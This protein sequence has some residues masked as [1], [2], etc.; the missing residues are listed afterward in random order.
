MF[1]PMYITDELNENH[2]IS[3]SYMSLF[4][5]IEEAGRGNNST[6]LQ[7]LL[8]KWMFISFGAYFYPFVLNTVFF[9]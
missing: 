9:S 3:F 4:F 6:N 2:D 5:L 7:V 1:I 8:S